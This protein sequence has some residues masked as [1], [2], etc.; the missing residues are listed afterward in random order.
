MFRLVVRPKRHPLATRAA[1]ASSLNFFSSLPL[2]G[3]GEVPVERSGVAWW[4]WLEG[5]G[6]KRRERPLLTG[7]VSGRWGWSTPRKWVKVLNA[8]LTRPLQ[9][10]VDVTPK[11][12]PQPNAPLG[13]GTRIGYAANRAE[14]KQKRYSV[15]GDVGNGNCDIMRKEQVST[16][17]LVEI[18]EFPVDPSLLS[19]VR[20]M[21]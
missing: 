10:A 8:H 9:A 15:L 20:Y 7:N 19:L 6:L 16:Y 12:K 13:L 17:L 1:P 18:D 2:G 21:L 4:V 5:L 14:R 11:S 3:N